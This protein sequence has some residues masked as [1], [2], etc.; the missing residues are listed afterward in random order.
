MSTTLLMH[1]DGIQGSQTFTDIIGHEVNSIIGQPVIDTTYSKFG[2]ASGFFDQSSFFTFPAHAD[3]DLSTSDFTIEFW[4]RPMTASGFQGFLSTWANWAVHY[5]SSQVIFQT[6]NDT[7]GGAIDITNNWHHIAV[8]CKNNIVRIF[9]DGGLLVYN[10]LSNPI[11]NQSNDLFVGDIN[12]G[13]LLG[14]LDEVRMIKGTGL[15]TSN[16]IPL[17]SAF[18]DQI[19]TPVDLTSN[20]NILGI[21]TDGSSYSGG[22]DFNV[23]TS[24]TLSNNILGTFRNFDGIPF[25]LAAPD[26]PNAISSQN[27]II[28]IPT[29]N[30]DAI[31]VLA[32]TFNGNNDGNFVITYDDASADL[33]V[34]TIESWT[35]QGEIENKKT[36]LEMSYINNPDGSQTVIPVYLTRYELPV[37]SEKQV[38]SLTLPNVPTICVF[39]VTAT[40]NIEQ[41]VPQTYDEIGSGEIALAGSAIDSITVGATTYNEIGSGGIE[42]GGDGTGTNHFVGFIC[43]SSNTYRGTKSQYIKTKTGGALLPAITVCTQHLTI[44]DEHIA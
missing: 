1:F 37:D 35:L 24:S 10:T 12:G 40:L 17:Q 8:S 44:I 18:P 22:L 23:P 39:S 2:G 11:G 43:K 26:V 29:G 16:F 36:S 31:S 6:L 4:A 5:T 25:V 38:V 15:Y 30:Y 42:L 3:W 41:Y 14:S 7:I 20:F 34:Q 13:N 21:T 28:T 19:V 9:V 32:L 33:I 27:T